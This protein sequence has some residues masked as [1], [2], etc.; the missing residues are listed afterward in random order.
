MAKS[1]PARTEQL[2][3]GLFLSRRGLAAGSGPIA[4]LRSRRIGKRDETK[5]FDA[6]NSAETE[7]AYSWKVI[8]HPLAGLD[9]NL[10]DFEPRLALPG[11]FLEHH[12]QNRRYSDVLLRQRVLCR[13]CSRG[14]HSAWLT[15]AFA[16]RADR[17]QLCERRHCSLACGLVTVRFPY[18]HIVVSPSH[19]NSDTTHAPISPST[20]VANGGRSTYKAYRIAVSALRW[21]TISSTVS[22]CFSGESCRNRRSTR[23]LLPSK[24][25]VIG[26]L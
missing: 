3:A 8:W 16:Q 24:L 18:L 25:S 21:F 11:L 10:I 22:F 19:A 6:R 4:G 13:C 17:R 1:C 12:D 9:L 26:S 5:F 15:A 23:T 14:R 20:R 2:R 7:V